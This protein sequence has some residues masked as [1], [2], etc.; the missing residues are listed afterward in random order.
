MDF[1]YVKDVARANILAA[2]S[3][4]TDEVFN[5]GTGKETSLRELALMLLDIMNSK[6][7]LEHT[8]ARKVGNLARRLAGVSK[9]EKMIGFKA[10]YDLES[11]LRELVEYWLQHKNQHQ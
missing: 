5:V 1:V 9:A 11:G 8:D 3:D 2:K 6:A 10:E 4:A 7:D